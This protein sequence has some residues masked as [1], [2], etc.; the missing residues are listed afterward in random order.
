MDLAGA[1]AGL[2]RPGI[3]GK[4]LRLPGIRAAWV[5]SC[6]VAPGSP[7]LI[8]PPTGTVSVPVSILECQLVV[9][10]A[11]TLLLVVV[12]GVGVAGIVVAGVVVLRISTVTAAIISSSS[13]DVLQT[14][15][16]HTN[17]VLTWSL[18]SPPAATVTAIVVATKQSEQASVCIITIGLS[19]PSAAGVVVVAVVVVV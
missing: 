1:G 9:T 6:G 10:L 2:V 13:Q 5:A 16:P 18:A 3:V 7:G 17:S 15:E 8:S 12:A 14:E 19:F 11:S 4:P